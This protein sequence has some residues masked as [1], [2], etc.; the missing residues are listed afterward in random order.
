MVYIFRQLLLVFS[1]HGTSICLYFNRNMIEIKKKKKFS[2][3]ME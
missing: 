1:K 3:S 2:P